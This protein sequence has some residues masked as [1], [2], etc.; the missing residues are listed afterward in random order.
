M[1]DTEVIFIKL[2]VDTHDKIV[3]DLAEKVF[4]A[5]KKSLIYVATEDR[6]RK[7]D[8]LLWTWKQNS[9]IPHCKKNDVQTK[10]E[11]PVQIATEIVPDDSDVLILADASESWTSETFSTVIDLAQLYDLALRD[12]ARA[13]YKSYRDNGY[14]LRDMEPGEFLQSGL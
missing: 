13:R 5:G 10:H 3:C 6:A 2:N 7:I 11:E 4:L 9:F 14:K 1:P 8:D 12:N